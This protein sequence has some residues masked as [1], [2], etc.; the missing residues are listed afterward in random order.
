MT[1]ARTTNSERETEDVGIV[2]GRCVQAGD[3]VLLIGDLG[4]GK[5]AFVRGMVLGM[6]GEAAVVSSPTFAIVQQYATRV[7]LFHADLY[8]LEAREV[9]DLGLEELAESG[10]L[11]VEWGDRMQARPRDAIEVRITDMGGDRR[12]L[13][14]RLPDHTPWNEVADSLRASIPPG[15]SAPLS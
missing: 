7:P 14:V 4:A 13:A 8:R 15:S 12:E 3:V 10:V 11:V 5:T 6:G 9:P 1:P 2:V